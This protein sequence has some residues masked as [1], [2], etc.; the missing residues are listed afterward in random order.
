MT[1][2]QA[3]LDDLFCWVAVTG[4]AMAA[5]GSSVVA[6]SAVMSP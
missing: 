6:F 2:M 3:L 4:L 5:Y 1:T